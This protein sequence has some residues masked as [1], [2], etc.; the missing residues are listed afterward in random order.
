MLNG[1]ALQQTYG[2]QL[3]YIVEFLRSPC[4][5]RE[6]RRKSEGRIFRFSIPASL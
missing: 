4:G 6:M 5:M 2:N 1:I 3:F